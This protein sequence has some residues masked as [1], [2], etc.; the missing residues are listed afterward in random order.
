MDRFF[1]SPASSGCLT[2]NYFRN[3]A[4]RSAW[5]VC[6]GNLARRSLN[7]ATCQNHLEEQGPHERQ[8]PGAPGEV[9]CLLGDNGAGKSR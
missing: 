4:L 8:H 9:I 2:N 5:R 3:L 1:L 6:L 7:C